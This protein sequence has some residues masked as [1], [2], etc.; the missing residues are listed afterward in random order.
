MESGLNTL[1]V[2]WKF[3]FAVLFI[4][5]R[6]AFSRV[7]AICE[8]GVRVPDLYLLPAVLISET[9]DG[10]EKSRG[11]KVNTSIVTVEKCKHVS[12]TVKLDTQQHHVG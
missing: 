11:T 5:Q 7:S 10:Q 9:L 1:Q 2:H 4:L 12:N 8:Y 3:S 6:L